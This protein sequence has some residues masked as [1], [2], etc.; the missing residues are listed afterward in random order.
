M[1]LDVPQA[2]TKGN[3]VVTSSTAPA[4][5]T[6]TPVT[7]NP[8]PVA[9]PLPKVTQVVSKKSMNSYFFSFLHLYDAFALYL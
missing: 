5:P 9:S 6:H 4:T 8:T 7:T 1:V 3:R 2:K